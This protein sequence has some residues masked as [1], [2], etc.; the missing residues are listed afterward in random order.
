MYEERGPSGLYRL[1]TG[2]AI[3]C[4]SWCHKTGSPHLL[5]SQ[6]RV[7]KA[8]MIPGFSGPAME[9]STIRWY[10]FKLH[11]EDL[12]K[13]LKQKLNFSAQTLLCSSATTNSVKI[14][15]GLWWHYW[16]HL[17]FTL[18]VLCHSAVRLLWGDGL[19]S[20]HCDLYRNVCWSCLSVRRRLH[21]IVYIYTVQHIYLA[22]PSLRKLTAPKSFSFWSFQK[23]KQSLVKIMFCSTQAQ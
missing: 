3:L 10:S 17:H 16:H 7:S 13:K 9:K 18:D 15:T 22:S 2:P 4:E 1:P 14:G 11:V 23:S 8:S 12:V 5:V 6:R 20:H 21:S 19:R